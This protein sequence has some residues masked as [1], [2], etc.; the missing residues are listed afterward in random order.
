MLNSI[1]CI[2]SPGAV[3][4]V[5]EVK[6]FSPRKC[7]PALSWISASRAENSSSGKASFNFRSNLAW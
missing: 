1:F 7:L 5:F 4:Q 2:R 3:F 6:G